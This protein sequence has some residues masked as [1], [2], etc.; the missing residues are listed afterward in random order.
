MIQLNSSDTWGFV[1]YLVDRGAALL[2]AGD[3][4]SRQ[5]LPLGQGLGLLAS[6]VALPPSMNLLNELASPC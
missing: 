1:S 4:A 6:G 3:G 2:V 5:V